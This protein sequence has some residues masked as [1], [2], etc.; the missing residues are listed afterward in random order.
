MISLSSEV[1]CGADP[2]EKSMSTFMHQ[3][4]GVLRIASLIGIGYRPERHSL[5]TVSHMTGRP[6]RCTSV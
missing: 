5:L 2:T 3:T 1:L 4:R 6:E